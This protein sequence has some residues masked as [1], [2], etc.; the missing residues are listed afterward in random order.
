MKR[1]GP[2]KPT[3][4]EMVAELRAEAAAYLD[5]ARRISLKVDRNLMIARARELEQRALELEL[6]SREE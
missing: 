5:I 6:A 1:M 2:R 3:A 4:A